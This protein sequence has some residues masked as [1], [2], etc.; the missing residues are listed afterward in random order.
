MAKRTGLI[1]VAA[2]AAAALIG[3]KMS[4][5]KPQRTPTPEG[6]TPPKDADGYEQITL[7][8]LRAPRRVPLE[9]DPLPGPTWVRQVFRQA[10]AART[11]TLQGGADLALPSLWRFDVVAPPGAWLVLRLWLQSDYNVVKEKNDPRCAQWAFAGLFTPGAYVPIV[12]KAKP[13][14]TCALMSWVVAHVAVDVTGRVDL[15]IIYPGKTHTGNNRGRSYTAV[16]EYAI[17]ASKPPA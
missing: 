1:V 4:G 8:A 10:S 3:S 5:P 17:L 11:Q 12:L 13:V 9:T 14:A 15:R 2:A 7:T 16:A 6:W